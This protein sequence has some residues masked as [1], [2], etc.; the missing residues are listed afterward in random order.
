MTPPTTLYVKLLQSYSWI[1]FDQ[2]AA[3][4][5]SCFEGAGLSYTNDGAGLQTKSGDTTHNSVCQGIKQLEPN[6]IS[7]N[8]LRVSLPALK[9][10]G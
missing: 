10:R 6:Q 7:T 9:G 2:S 1:K 4:I 3:S 8:Q 5:T